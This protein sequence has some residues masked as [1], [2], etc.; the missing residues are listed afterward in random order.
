MRTMCR[1]A[2]HLHFGRA[3]LAS[4]N[5]SAGPAREIDGLGNGKT[6]RDW[7]ARFE[8]AYR[9]C[10][11]ENVTLVGG[12]AGI[13]TKYQPALNALYRRQVVIRE[14][15]GATEGMFGQQRDE[16][17]AWVPNCD[18][19]FF[20]VQSCDRVNRERQNARYCL[21]NWCNTSGR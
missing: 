6:T 17:R 18:P 12:V 9:R 8:L 5:E 16:K 10:K 7:E 13:N 20:E 1:R 2:S 15:Y 14:I 21:R 4:H 3:L 19:S 11:D